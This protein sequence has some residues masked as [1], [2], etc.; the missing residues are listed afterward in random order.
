M[1]KQFLL[2]SPHAPVFSYRFWRI[3]WCA[4]EE[5]ASRGSAA[6]KVIEIP[7]ADMPPLSQGL[8]AV[9][10]IHLHHPLLVS[11]TQLPADFMGKLL[12]V[13]KA[14]CSLS[15]PDEGYIYFPSGELFV[16]CAKDAIRSHNPLSGKV[17]LQNLWNQVLL[18][19]EDV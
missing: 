13:R 12:K 6:D 2:L 7:A 1:K 18:R 9:E 14:T 15:S 4:Q 8:F 3:L 10:H 5:A 19:G 11:T 17:V 16:S